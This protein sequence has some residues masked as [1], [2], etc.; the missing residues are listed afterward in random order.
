M[1]GIFYS[2]RFVVKRVRY[3]NNVNNNN[4][5]EIYQTIHCSMW[6]VVM[7]L[8]CCVIIIFSKSRELEESVHGDDDYR[9]EQVSKRRVLLVCH[10]QSPGSCSLCH[11]H[12]QLLPLQRE[13]IVL[14]LH[15]LYL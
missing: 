11:C 4:I 12:P 14:Q 10:R 3:Y 5:I 7:W 1:Y 9:R 15:Q 6:A 8:L 13:D 2:I